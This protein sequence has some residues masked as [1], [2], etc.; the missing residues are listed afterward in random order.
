MVDRPLPVLA[1]SGFCMDA[2]PKDYG[3]YSAQ[4]SVGEGGREYEGVSKSFRTESIKIYT[5]T[6]IN[7][8]SE[9][10]QN[11]MAAKVT[12]LIHKIAK[13]LHLV[14]ESSTICS[15]RSR[16]PVR[17]LLDTPSYISC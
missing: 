7:T 2:A 9:A 6:T 17:K 15:S 14:A 16:S 8:R 13:E 12:R 5:L 11:V 10:T 4:L 3:E 1:L